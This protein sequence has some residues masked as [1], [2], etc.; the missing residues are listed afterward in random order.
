MMT[1]MIWRPSLKDKGNGSTYRPRRVYLGLQ[2]TGLYVTKEALS[3]LPTKVKKYVKVQECPVVDW[4]S[5]S[6][7]ETQ[8]EKID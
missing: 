3:D 8:E 2:G 6:A 4:P 1:P 7:A 5:A